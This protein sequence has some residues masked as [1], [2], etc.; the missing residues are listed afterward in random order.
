MARDLNNVYIYIC[1]I[2]IR[3]LDPSK[4]PCKNFWL[5]R[6]HYQPLFQLHHGSSYD[7]VSS[8]ML[9]FSGPKSEGIVNSPPTLQENEPTFP[10]KREEKENHRLKSADW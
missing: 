5:Q 7:K 9:D 4:S 3:L 2:H 1:I 10:T 8:K 6:A